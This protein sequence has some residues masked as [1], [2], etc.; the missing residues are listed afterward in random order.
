MR[1]NQTVS[2]L[3][4]RFREI[5]IRPATRHGQNFLIDINL[6]RLIVQT[7]DLG[8]DDVV[9][10]VGTG[11]GALTAMLSPIVASAA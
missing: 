3:V 10:E 1:Q 9:L 8:P 4:R 5:G 2:F 7:A 6:Q 11:T